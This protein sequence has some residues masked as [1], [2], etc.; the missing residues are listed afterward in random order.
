[1]RGRMFQAMAVLALSLALLTACVDRVIDGDFDFDEMFHEDVPLP[2]DPV[3]KAAVL[4]LFN[5]YRES[6]MWEIR[7][8][9]VL[10]I[11]QMIPT[12]AYIQEHDPKTL[13]C[14]CVEFEARYNVPWT[15]QDKSPWETTV[16]NVLVMQT[17][18]DH[19]IAMRPSQICPMFCR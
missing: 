10:G 9:R 17:R 1:M 8:P 19:L 11:Q 3:E 6:T 7:D 18:A 14:V 4:G 15:T 12:K 16:R 5:S 13:F 2:E